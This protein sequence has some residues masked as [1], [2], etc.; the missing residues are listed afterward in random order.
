MYYTLVATNFMMMC[1]HEFPL[2]R[3]HSTFELGLPH[4]DFIFLPFHLDP[5]LNNFKCVWVCKKALQ[6]FVQK[7]V[8]P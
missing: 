8:I 2:T 1:V 4:K 7:F 6:L 3:L 5:T